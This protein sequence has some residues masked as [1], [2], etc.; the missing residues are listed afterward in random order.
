MLRNFLFPRLNRRFFI[1]LTLVAAVTWFACTRV[2]V[3]MRIHGISM[4]PTYHDGDFGICWRLRYLFHP[5]QRGDIVAVRFA[6]PSAVLLK[7]V[8]ALAGDEVAFR[9][10]TLYVNGIAQDEPYTAKPC[11]WE[12][13]PRR[14]ESGK[15][16]VVGDNRSLPIEDHVFGQTETKRV[17][18]TIL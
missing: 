13:P 17:I 16:Y 8:V 15:V 18:G 6:G 12:L 9:G 4:E 2:L 3:P 1:R 7:R 5:P 11:D 10:G 14:V